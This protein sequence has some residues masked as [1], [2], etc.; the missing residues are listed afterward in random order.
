M[1]KIYADGQLLY[2]SGYQEDGMQCANPKIS[3][4]AGTA[5]SV[6]FTMIHGH[7]LYGSIRKMKTR[8]TVYMRDI[9]IFRG[10]VLNWTT[11]F[12]NQNS[13]HCEGDL[14]Y[15]LDSLQPP[16]IT[17]MTVS[18]Y[19]GEIINEHNIQ[20][21]TEKQFTLGIVGIAEA[22]QEIELTDATYRDTR[23]TIDS[24]LIGVYGGILRTRTVGETTYLDYIN[25]YGITSSQ[26]IEFGSNIL[27]ISEN[28]NAMDLYTV[29]LPTGDTMEEG[30]EEG[31]E[32]VEP[33]PNAE[34]KPPP[35]PLTIESVNQGSKLLEKLDGVAKYGR[36]VH[37]EHF[38]GATTPETLLGVAND[39]FN[40][41]YRDPGKTITVKALDLNLV[42]DSLS[43]FLIGQ[44]IHVYAPYHEID[45][46]SHCLAINYDLQNLENTQLTIGPME[47]VVRPGYMKA[48]S[49]AAGKSL[50]EKAGK[51]LDGPSG[52]KLGQAFK[53]ITEGKDWVKIH[54][55]RITLLAGELEGNHALI[56]LTKEL[57]LA[58]VVR[59][60]EELGL[61]E[62]RITIEADKINAEVTRSI[63]E[64]AELAGRITVTSESV[65]AEVT[66]ATE[67]E[68]L[69]RGAIL[70]EADKITA[71]VTRS[72]AAE[73]ALSGRLTIEADKITAE[74]A[75]ATTSE[76]VLSGRITVTESEIDL[77]V[78]KAGII[79]AINVAPGVVTINADKVDISG[80][81]TAGGIAVGDL[82]A[83]NAKIE[84]LKSGAT[85]ASNLVIDTN[86]TAGGTVRAPFINATTTLSATSIN[87][88]FITATVSLSAPVITL[89]G[90]NLATLLTNKASTT[91]LTS[92]TNTVNAQ[93][94]S[95]GAHG[96]A[97]VNLQNGKAESN[98]AHTGVYL[99]ANAQAADSAKLNGLT[100]DYYSLWN[101]THSGYAP[102]SHDHYTRTSAEFVTNVT[103]SKRDVLQT[104]GGTTVS[105]VSSISVT[106]NTYYF[107][108]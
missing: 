93:G 25:D 75:R 44:Y 42:D 108:T 17:K 26:T 87:A 41:S 5:G 79:T 68:G 14:T 47:N 72:T 4:A 88:E 59:H 56:E 86:V 95:L 35:L 33:D 46:W 43:Q 99:N 9:L 39:F 91:A 21:E 80:I 83:V 15:L 22:G 102:A 48:S 74:V 64:G 27:D 69:L 65:L 84:N 100:P 1:F 23:S 51:A 101:H 63:D 8:I 16:R 71:E 85:S 2:S 12:Y 32:E 7:Y 40:K 82:S 52:G 62:G 31:E 92:L 106:K 18:A 28:E 34:P 13:V 57:I 58:E 19:L 10:R 67:E 38:P 78:T 45:I 105:V 54:A 49:S 60:D 50:S 81:I 53:N 37:T 30:V 94:N 104:M 73:G 70:V 107:Y 29:L 89:N 90:S 3:L 77:R 20:V 6:D 55:D 24:D 98:H 97:I 11:D 96:T 66:R 61:L 36:I 76:G 103:S